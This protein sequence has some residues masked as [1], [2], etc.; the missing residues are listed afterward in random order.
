MVFIV[1]IMKWECLCQWE[2]S[3]SHSSYDNGDNLFFLSIRSPL[4]PSLC[5]TIL[6]SPFPCLPSRHVPY[7]LLSSNSGCLPA[8]LKTSVVAFVLIPGNAYHRNQMTALATLVDLSLHQDSNTWIRLCLAPR[9]WGVPVLWQ[10][11]GLVTFNLPSQ[12][13]CVLCHAELPFLEMSPPQ[14]EQL[15]I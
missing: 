4:L 5:Q 3:P 1:I 7:A 13:C 9:Y 8:R 14:A 2:F 12:Q 6:P 15:W 11:H 10:L